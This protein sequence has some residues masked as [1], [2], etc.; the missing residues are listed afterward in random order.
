[1]DPCNGQLFAVEQNTSLQISKFSVMNNYIFMKPFD[2]KM[3]K[4]MDVLFIKPCL[5]KEFRFY[6]GQLG[7]V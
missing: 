2:Y 7:C 4:Q 5:E 3:C 6:L 1:M